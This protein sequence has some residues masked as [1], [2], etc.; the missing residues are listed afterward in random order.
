MKTT[1]LELN[2]ILN[3]MTESELNDALVQELK[4]F[5]RP[6]IVTRLHQRYAKVRAARERD[7][8]L[9]QCVKQ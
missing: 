2:K 9:L 5:K 1:W 8:L 6:T 4:T 3:S 7:E